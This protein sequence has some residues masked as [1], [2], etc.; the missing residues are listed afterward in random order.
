MLFTSTGFGDGAVNVCDIHL[1][2][3]AR[4]VGCNACIVGDMD[5]GA[6]DG[7]ILRDAAKQS[8]ALVS[9]Y[10]FWKSIPIFLMSGPTVGGCNALQ[11]S[12]WISFRLGT[13]LDLEKV[14]LVS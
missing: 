14:V 13:R 7:A 12:C 10:G 6:V 8:I 2:T 1:S 5:D 11:R 4:T 9:A 3:K